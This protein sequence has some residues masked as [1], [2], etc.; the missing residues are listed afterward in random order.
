MKKR[1]RQ[2]GNKCTEKTLNRKV[3]RK[4]RR[5]KTTKKKMAQSNS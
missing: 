1:K 5:K 2:N 4:E 3:E